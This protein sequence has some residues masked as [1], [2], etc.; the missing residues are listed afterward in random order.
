MAG[1]E[2]LLT[3]GEIAVTLVGFSGLISV[4]RARTIHEL[5]VRDLSALALIIATGSL[6]LAFSLVPLPI[7]YTG[8]SEPTVWRIVSASFAIVLLG[9][10]VAFLIVNRRLSAAGYIER[11]PVLNRFTIALVLLMIVLLVLTSSAVLPPGPAAYLATLVVCLL[12][13]LTYVAVMLMLTRRGQDG[14]TGSQ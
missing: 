10:V 8:L 11:T 6:A 14:G 4:F 3:I 1:T 13:C 5:E 7:A 9:A 12:L 2:E